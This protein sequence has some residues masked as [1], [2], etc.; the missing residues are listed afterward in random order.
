MDTWKVALQILRH[1]DKYPPHTQGWVIVRR[2]NRLDWVPGIILGRIG[3]MW[4]RVIDD[5]G[6][7]WFIRYESQ[8][9]TQLLKP[10]KPAQRLYLTCQ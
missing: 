9:T 2:D 7:S 1:L 8:F 10:Y 3:N 5:Q 4:R 6:V